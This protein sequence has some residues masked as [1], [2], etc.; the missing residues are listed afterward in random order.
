MAAFFA[1]D[2]HNAITAHYL[3][4]AADFLH[5]RAHFH[6]IFSSRYRM[7]FD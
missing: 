2:P 3:A 5:G 7:Q 1:D 6:E 4:V